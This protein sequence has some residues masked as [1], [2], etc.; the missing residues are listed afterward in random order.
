[1][2][3]CGSTFD[4]AAT[5]CVSMHRNIFC[6]PLY[7]GSAVVEHMVGIPHKIV[8]SGILFRYR[9]IEEVRAGVQVPVVGVTLSTHPQ[10]FHHEYRPRIQHLGQSWMH[11]NY[12]QPS[13]PTAAPAVDDDACGRP[14]RG[15]EYPIR[16]GG[17]EVSDSVSSCD[18]FGEDVSDTEDP[19]EQ[20]H[21]SEVQDILRQCQLG[22]VS[23]SSPLLSLNIGGRHRVQ[24][25][26]LINYNPCMQQ[27]SLS[28]TRFWEACMGPG[29]QRQQEMS[30]SSTH[31]DLGSVHGQ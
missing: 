27:A 24:W 9:A 19:T 21:L 18:S 28:M 30:K 23:G 11:N 8:T 3:S 10:L 1:M 4:L 2:S 17:S 15:G 25:H 7:R 12:A 13:Q 20:L 22:V 16:S 29:F 6:L 14:N 5:H 31:W 26:E